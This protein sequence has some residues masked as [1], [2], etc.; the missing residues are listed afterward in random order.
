M[1]FFLMGLGMGAMATLTYLY[2]SDD[3]VE[4]VDFQDFINYRISMFKIEAPIRILYYAEVNTFDGL[5]KKVTGYYKNTNDARLATNDL[6]RKIYAVARNGNYD[7]FNDIDAKKHADAAKQA[8]QEWVKEQYD[9]TMPMT[10]RKNAYIM[11][12]NSKEIDRG[13]TNK[14]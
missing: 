2:C 13:T 7:H 9:Y 8:Y 11:P 6:V 1:V 5:H 14:D 3:K 12:I 10:P 4:M